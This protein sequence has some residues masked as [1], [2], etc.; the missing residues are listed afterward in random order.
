M[1][2]AVFWDI[3]PQFVP[4]RRHITSPLQSPAVYC[5]VGYVVIT[6]MTMKN[7]VFWDAAPCGYCKNRRIGGSIA[8]VIRLTIIG[9]ARTTLAVTSNWS[10]PRR[11]TILLVTYYIVFLRIVLQLLAT[12]NVFPSSLILVNMM[13]E[14]I[15]SSKTSV[16]IRATR[17]N[18]CH[19]NLPT[20]K[21]NVINLFNIENALSRSKT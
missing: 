6:A 15:R 18:I 11:N 16:P 7:T 21:F 12:A 13:I 4:H 17:R 9:E 14:V 19:E 2:N 1:Q 5:C 8:S 3:R 10:T 20:F